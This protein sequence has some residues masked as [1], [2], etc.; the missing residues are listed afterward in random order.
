MN[1]T[2]TNGRRASW[3]LRAGSLGLGVLAGVLAFGVGL[4]VSEDLRLLY[5][6]GAILLFCGA[7]WVG[8][9]SGRDWLSALLFYVPLAGMF[10]FFVLG[11][12]P[13]LWPNLLLWGLAIVLGLFLLA[14]RPGRGARISGVAILLAISTWYCMSYIPAQMKRATNHFSNGAAP[15]FVF[16]AVSEGSGTHHGDARQNSGDRFLWHLVPSLSRRAAGNRTR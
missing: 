8:V 11:Q 6:S 7:T 3:K 10:C 12:L 16:Q 2:S 5:V 1:L 13:F 9:K 14:I 4:A 15:A